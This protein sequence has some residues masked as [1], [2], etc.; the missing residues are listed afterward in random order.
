MVDQHDPRLGLWPLE[1]WG[2]GFEILSR[3]E[4]LMYIRVVLSSVRHR[5]CSGPELH[6]KES[7][8][9]SKVLKCRNFSSTPRAK[10]SF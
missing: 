5:L 2:Y 10:G 7:Y 8:Q 9:T 3:L 4:A 6:F 1:H